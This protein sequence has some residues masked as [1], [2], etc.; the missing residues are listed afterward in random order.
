MATLQWSAGPRK[1]RSRRA[2]H[3]LAALT[4]GHSYTGEVSE[5]WC[6]YIYQVPWDPDVVQLMQKQATRSMQWV[7]GSATWDPLPDMPHGRS[8]AVA[9]LL[10]DGRLAVAGGKTDDHLPVGLY[11]EDLGSVHEDSDDVWHASVV[12]LAA[13]GSGWAVVPMSCPRE[14]AVAGL[15]PSGRV[16]VAG[17][18][19]RWW[20]ALATAEQWDPVENNYMDSTATD[21]QGT[22]PCGGVH[23]GGRAVRFCGRTGIDGGCRIILLG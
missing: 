9:V 3:A 12:V 15:L 13:D 21:G 10:L 19:K 11:D 1:L 17:G 4:D 7:P 18:T 23:A 6:T 14:N 5:G 20:R 22:Q 16:I 8:G 2:Q